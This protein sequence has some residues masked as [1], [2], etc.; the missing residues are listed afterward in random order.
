MKNSK[1]KIIIMGAGGSATVISS[2]IEDLHDAGEN[3]DMLGFLDDKKKRGE[4]VNNYPILGTVSEYEKYMKM[5]DIFFIYA[6]INPTQH[7]ERIN[8]LL[9]KNISANKFATIVHPTAVVSRYSTLGQ[10]VVLMPGVVLSPN[11]SIGNNVLIFANSFIGHDTVVEDY[12]FVANCVSVGSTV[13]LKK[14]VYVGSNASILEKV[15]MGEYAMAGL[16]TVVLKDIPPTKRAVGNP[17][18]IIE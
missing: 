5:D 7:K 14:G 9:G 8:M 13:R 2:V 1:H 11:V 12:C 17:A 15:T 10:G 18:R 3:I 4:I 6:L 16:G